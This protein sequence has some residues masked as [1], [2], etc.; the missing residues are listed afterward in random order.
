[1]KNCLNFFLGQFSFQPIILLFLSCLSLCYS[2]FGRKMLG[3]EVGLVNSV[4]SLPKVH[5]KVYL[6][7][8]NNLLWSRF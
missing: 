7:I 3:E 1:M 5:T 2:G 4:N 8:T 6:N